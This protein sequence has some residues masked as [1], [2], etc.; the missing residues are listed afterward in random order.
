MIENKKIGIPDKNTIGDIIENYI[1]QEKALVDQLYFRVE[2]GPTIGSFR[3]DLW[4]EM[5]RQIIPKKFVI[6]KSVFI[7]D[8]NGKVSNEVD[9][10]IFDETYTPYIFRYGRLKFI[11]IEAVAVVIECKS[12]SVKKSRLKSWIDSIEQLQTSGISCARMFTDIVTG[13]NTRPSTQTATRPL[14]IL[15]CLEEDYGKRK[16]KVRDIPFDFIIQA[17]SD[18]Q[19][20]EI[21]IADDKK[22]LNE[23]YISLNHVNKSPNLEIKQNDALVNMELD[24]YQVEKNGVNIALLSLNLQLNQLLMLINNPLLFPHIAYAKMFNK[25]AE[26]AKDKQ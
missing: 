22:N 5:F 18:K 24:H 14:K 23:W 25:F 15:C 9:L 1:Q 10:V 8:S 26:E 2:H 20:L 17:Q 11:P 3:E 19:R 21:E 7:I 16:A 4:E 12:T 13:V 6:E